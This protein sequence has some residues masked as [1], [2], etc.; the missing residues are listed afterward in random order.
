[1][2]WNTTAKTTMISTTP[3]PSITCGRYVD[4]Y[5]IL[6]LEDRFDEDSGDADFGGVMLD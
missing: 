4:C 5:S 2:T 3:P 1:M 6:L